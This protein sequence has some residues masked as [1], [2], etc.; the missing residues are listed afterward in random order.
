MRDRFNAFIQRHDVAW[1]LGMAFLAVIYVAAGFALDNPAADV[2][3]AL[4][5]TESVLTAVFLAEFGIRL[6]AAYDRKRYLRGHWIDLIALIP[7]TRGFRLARLLRLLRLIRAFAGLFRAMG[8]I[9]RLAEHR[10]LAAIVV[11]WGA[12]MIICCAALYLVER[13]I[14]PNLSTPFD[15]VWWGITTMT[16]VGYGDVVPVTAEG[17]VAASGLMPLGIGLFSAVTGIVTSYL[18]TQRATVSPDP[19]AALARLAELA[20][21]GTITP[22]QFEGKRAELLAR[23]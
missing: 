2:A 10:G 21:E 7:A 12:V 4:Q 14:N 22:A 19:L 18:L 13:D 6:T 20:R 9:E 11:G 17:R 8:H 1:E 5:A 23:I 16:T 3:P 15:A